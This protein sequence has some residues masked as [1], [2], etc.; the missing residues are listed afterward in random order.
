M[1]KDREIWIDLTKGIACICVALG[2][3][4]SSV[5][6]ITGSDEFIILQW[7]V[8]TVYYFHVPLFFVCSGFLYERLNITNRMSFLKKKIIELGI[9][10]CFF[11]IMKFILKNHKCCLKDILNIIFINPIPP[12]WYLY[13]LLFIFLLIPQVKKTN[14]V[15]TLFVFSVILRILEPYFEYKVC[16]LISRSMICLVWFTLGMLIYHLDSRSKHY[17]LINNLYYGIV[18]CIIFIIFSTIEFVYGI[19]NWISNTI[20]AF[21]SILGIINVIRNASTKF[22]NVNTQ[23]IAEYSMP[24]YL[25]HTLFG[26]VY[27][28][29]LNMINLNLNFIIIIVGA[30]F[31]V[32]G[33]CLLYFAI[34]KKCIFD[35]FIYPAKYIKF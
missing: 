11:S 9:P 16:Y 33:P 1:H 14:S 12:Y 18:M 27:I 3:F 15:L 28:K 17:K 7:F 26:M 13:I 22:K 4:F 6:S 31:T 24:I 23:I 5:I 34:R 29:F 20:L 10:F 32:L 2:H 8:K 30:I 19:N 21:I 35:F 25:I